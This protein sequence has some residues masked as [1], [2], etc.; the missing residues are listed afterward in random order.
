MENFEIVRD[1]DA[2]LAF[3]GELLAKVSSN[4]IESAIKQ[5]YFS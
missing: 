2:T 5:F 3:D 4:P 1:N